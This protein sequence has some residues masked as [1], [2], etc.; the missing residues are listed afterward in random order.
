MGRGAP[1][2]GLP[3]QPL[4]A[5]A[6]DPRPRRAVRDADRRHPLAGPERLRRGRAGGGRRAGSRGGR[7]DDRPDP[8]RGHRG[9]LPAAPVHRLG[10]GR[11]CPGRPAPAP[12]GG[13]HP[14]ADLH[15][16]PADRRTLARCPARLPVP[17]RRAHDD[18]RPRGRR[19]AHDRGGPAVPHGPSALRHRV[20]GDRGDPLD[21]GLQPDRPA[22]PAGRD[23]GPD[24]PDPGHRGRRLRAPPVRRPVPD[25]PDHQG[26]DVPGHPG[27]E[28]HHQAP[29]RRHDRGRDRVHGAGDPGRRRHPAGGQRGVRARAPGLAAAPA[30]A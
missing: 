21:R 20:P 30:S 16:L 25:Q 15:R 28:D 3:W 2:L 11:Q 12:P 7:P 17:R 27:P 24:H 26:R 29:D 6:G 5:P 19:S 10:R 4:G 13:D 22:I 23:P 9:V 1:R 18:P 14:G 8:R